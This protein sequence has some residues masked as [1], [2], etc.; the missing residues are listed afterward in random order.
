MLG[1][2]MLMLHYSKHG[3]CIL[4][5]IGAAF[6]GEHATDLLLICDGKETVRA[7]KLVL[8]AASPLIRMILEET[9]V[10][11]GETTVY[12]PDVQVCYFRLLLDFLYS[13]QVYVPASE[14]RHLQDLLAL[15]QIKPSIWKNSE[16]SN[17]RG[18]QKSVPLVDINRNEG[19]G[20]ND[21][22]Q[23]RAKSQE[24]LDS[25]HVGY[26]AGMTPHN[27]IV[28][29]ERHSVG[30]SEDGA[31]DGEDAD[32][33]DEIEEA[34]IESNNNVQPIVSS[35]QDDD[36]GGGAVGASGEGTSGSV[37]FAIEGV[38]DGREGGG[39]G[40]GGGGGEGEGGGG[41]GEEEEVEEEEGHIEVEGG[42]DG[43]GEGGSG[44]GGEGR[45]EGVESSGGEGGGRG[46]GGEGGEEGRIDE[47]AG[48][49]AT[50]G[51]AGD[52]GGSTTGDVRSESGS[53]RSGADVLHPDSLR[54]SAFVRQSARTRH[55]AARSGSTCDALEED[56]DFELDVEDREMVDKEITQSGAVSG[57]QRTEPIRNRRRSSS[58]PVNLSIVKQQQQDVD[59]DDANIDVETISNAPTKNLLPPRYLDPFRTKR[60]AYYIH[61]DTESLKPS[62][63]HELLHGSPDNYVVTPH[64]KRR[65]GFHNSPAQNPPFVPSYLEDLRTRKC[66]L[67]AP[68]SFLPDN[69]PPSP[70]TARTSDH[71]GT[72]LGNNHSPT[73][74]NNNNNNN[75]NTNNNNRRPPSTDNK[76][77]VAPFVYPWPTAALAAL[78][79]GPADLLTVPY[80]HAASANT[81]TSPAE[82]IQQMKNFEN[83]QAAEM[84]SARS[85]ATGGASVAGSGGSSG[86]G[87]SIGVSSLSGSG[88][89]P[90]VVGSG[91]TPV[92]EYRCEYCGKQFGMSWNLKTHLRVHTGEKPFACRLC[93]AMFKQKAHLL[94]H[95]CSVHRN[96]INS[97]ESGGRYTCCFCTLYFETL[98]E[99]VRHL[100][101]HHNNL[102]LSKN[103]HE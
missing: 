34:I 17:D 32:Y 101:G 20:P 27:I 93:V 13:G 39:G 92:R 87:G 42:E 62:L 89:G 63:E 58:D 4:Q 18:M 91:N 66:F 31:L 78:P 80:L 19:L 59:S 33:M 103:L 79:G 71:G 26:P 21:R 1:V 72:S 40:G 88:S 22:R 29:S 37:G 70:A 48:V 76:L 56:D 38:G 54:S 6:R 8:A 85:G 84:L 43:E 49:V 2:R 99:L 3:E 35:Q 61:S 74:N 16:N 65:P 86:G 53:S 5:E 9:P 30:S 57:V 28:K 98:Q 23:R 25:Q 55:S 44:A 45:R 46:G 47:G 36:N 64:R 15:L 90:T 94:K 100:S 14:V 12:F 77:A 7:H 96:I 83:S 102:L 50:G 68:V 52:E 75:N 11:E 51:G 95:L 60:K 81:D 97:P 24:L 10:L 82:L 41:G 67:S 69:R 73:H